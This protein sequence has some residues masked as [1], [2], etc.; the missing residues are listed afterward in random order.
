MSFSKA[1]LYSVW[2][3]L[4]KKCQHHLLHK[5]DMKI[6]FLNYIMSK[7]A[8][9]VLLTSMEE[10]HLF[11][12]GS[13]GDCFASGILVACSGG[14]PTIIGGLM[15]VIVLD[16]TAVGLPLRRCFSLRAGSPLLFAP[17]WCVPGSMTAGQHRRRSSIWKSRLRTWSLFQAFCRVLGAKFLGLVCNSFTFGPFC[18]FQRLNAANLSGASHPS[19]FKKKTNDD[20]PPG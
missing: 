2:L 1:K 14:S 9:H 10:V 4:A 6:Y 19:L 11:C 18:N 13:H 16:S 7:R 5:Y 12:F 15:P 17:K 3:I 8:K 20:K